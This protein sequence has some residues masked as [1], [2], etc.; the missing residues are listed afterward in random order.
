MFNNYSDVMS[1]SDA[2]EALSVGKNQ[3]YALLGSG[4]LKGFRMGHTWKIS[5]KNLEDFITEETKKQSA[6]TKTA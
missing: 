6:E 3:I 5:K 2:A 1:V 4:K